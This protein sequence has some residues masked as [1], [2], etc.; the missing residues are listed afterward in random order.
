MPALPGGP[1][2]SFSKGCDSVG[3]ESLCFHK[4]LQVR[5]L[6]ELLAHLGLN[7]E[8]QGKRNTGRRNGVG[9]ASS[10]PAPYQNQ[11]GAAPK[12]LVVDYFPQ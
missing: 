6:R 1:S 3:F 8:P 2:P 12:S 7:L 9:K 4:H 11:E 5:N 10:K